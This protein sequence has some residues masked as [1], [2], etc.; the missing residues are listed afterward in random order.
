MEDKWF[1]LSDPE[2]VW[3]PGRFVQDSGDSSTYENKDGEIIHRNNS[4]AKDFKEL[5][6][7][8]LN[9]E[10][11]NLIEMEEFSEGAILH[12]IRQ[13]YFAD[14]IYTN[15]GS[16]LVSVNPFKELQIYTPHILS[17]YKKVIE[18]NDPHV[19]QVAS[20]ALH[21]LLKDRQSQ[22]VIIS[23]E[24]GSGKTEATKLILQYLGDTAGSKDGVEQQILQSNPILEA[25]GNCKTLRNKNSSR[26]GKWMEI[27]FKSGKICGAKIINYLLEKSRVNSQAK[28]ERNYHAFYQLCQGIPDDLRE[29]L[30]VHTA[31][32]FEFLKKSE[33]FKVNGIDDFRDFSVTSLAFQKLQFNSDEVENV[34]RLLSGILWLG[35]INFKSNGDGSEISDPNPLNIASELL[36][37]DSK[38]LSDA[39]CYKKLLIR[40][41]VQMKNQDAIQ[42]ANARD[43][44]AKEIYGRLFDWLVQKINVFLGTGKSSSTIGVLDIFGFEVFEKNAFEQFCINYANEKLQQHFNHYIFKM[45]QNEY[46][47]EGVPF[48]TVSFVDNQAC[49]DLIE[50]NPGILS[51]IEEEV[52]FPQGSDENLAEK[53]HSTFA[54]SKKE[55][56]AH[57]K[58]FRQKR[59]AFI[60]SHYAGD[61]SYTSTG[62]CDKSKDEIHESLQ[63]T[64]L[65]STNFLM[66]Q[67]F[68]DDVPEKSDTKRGH[69]R[70]GSMKKSKTIGSKFKSQLTLLMKTLNSTKPH[71][72]RCIKPNNLMAGN[73]FDSSSSLRQFRYAGLF[74]AIRVRASGYSFR[75]PL[76]DFFKHYRFLV[77]LGERKKIEMLNAK[78]KCKQVLVDYQ[79]QIPSDDL[80]LGE[81]KMFYRKNVYLIL[82]SIRDTRLREYVVRM[83]C[84]S[85][86]FL[87]GKKLQLLRKA[88]KCIQEAI[89]KCTI[90]ATSEAMAFVE[91]FNIVLSVVTKLKSIHNALKQE[92]SIIENLQVAITKKDIDAIE[93]VLQQA[94]S[95]GLYDLTKDQSSKSVIDEAKISLKTFKDFHGVAKR[96]KQAIIEEDIKTLQECVQTSK[97]AG[98]TDGVEEAEKYLEKF[99]RDEALMKCIANAVQ[100]CDIPNLEDLLQKVVENKVSF[101]AERRKL[102]ADTKIAITDFYKCKIE[103]AVVSEDQEGIRDI[104]NQVQERQYQSLLRD[105]I[106]EAQVTLRRL[107]PSASFSEIAQEQDDFLAPLPSSPPVSPEIGLVS[108]SLPPFIPMIHETKPEQVALKHAVQSADIASV[109]K[110]VPEIEQKSSNESKT[111]RVGRAMIQKFNEMKVIR[112]NLEKAVNSMDRERMKAI[113]QEAREFDMTDD[114]F[115]VKAKKICYGMQETEFRMLQMEIAIRQEDLQR[116]K[117]IVNICQEQIDCP[118]VVTEGNTFISNY[119]IAKSLGAVRSKDSTSVSFESQNVEDLSELFQSLKGL[120]QLRN[121]PFLRSPSGIFPFSLGGSRS[122]ATMLIHQHEPISKSMLKFSSFVLKNDKAKSLKIEAK[123]IFKGILGFMGDRYHP[124]PNTLA[125]EILFRG[126]E[127]PNLRDEIF[128]QIIKQTSENPQEASLLRGWKLLFLALVTFHPNSDLVRKIILSH[129]AQVATP[130]IPKHLSFDTLENIA[131]NCYLQLQKN[132]DPDVEVP[133]VERIRELSELKSSTFYV[134][135]PSGNTID[136]PIAA[137]N[138]SLTVG[139][140][141]ALICSRLRIKMSSQCKLS[142]QTRDEEIN[143][144]YEFIVRNEDL[145]LSLLSHWQGERRI[146]PNLEYR[147]VFSDGSSFDGFQITPQ[148]VPTI[149][150][151]FIPP[152]SKSL[153]DPS[154]I[155]NGI[156][157]SSSGSFPPVDQVFQ[158]M[159]YEPVPPAPPAP[160][161]LLSPPAPPAPSKLLN[162][163]IAF[164]EENLASPPSKIPPLD[165]D[166]Q[167][168]PTVMAPPTP[169]PIP[170][171][172]SQSAK[173]ALQREASEFS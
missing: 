161:S 169:P 101:D 66:Q 105:E 154:I 6:V 93:G 125:H 50:K 133:T 3:V 158:P 82:E 27:S 75:Q 14:R 30:H 61:V 137:T 17:K 141:I 46:K 88:E 89:Q 112:L 23:G 117:D 72:I 25:F 45:E 55:T 35:N 120:H 36:E 118:D 94:E 173:S 166:S 103:A 15:I 48:E 106:L 115:V 54:K 47:K 62:F 147:F 135:V 7:S 143:F 142:V 68:N 21:N 57:Y 58:V 37:I 165:S 87:A 153:G 100:T 44:T 74:E 159:R 163:P 38:I 81:T 19:Y 8:S 140:A 60:V 160:L 109:Q 1:W 79:S 26:F 64:V 130:L 123:N 31:E 73:V 85:R 77:E 167:M 145:I 157:D 138:K 155:S 127:E 90:N 33:C 52:L 129:V 34:W 113:L 110:L 32:H 128:C 56:H 71:F 116:V 67:I 78:E 99:L 53:L 11:S 39:F 91:D 10:F 126:R 164:P 41:E 43:S 9:Q 18:D 49:L 170:T 122:V 144:K 131:A 148:D 96:M 51:L 92:P 114:D 40:G 172:I 42:A 168:K 65:S 136:I 98:F 70:V 83:Q 124:Y 63:E 134:Q 146:N 28:N 69:R 149:E 12:Q 132:E 4:E 156:L 76:E 84:V 24:S 102:M 162:S 29:K 95:L 108:T 16:I 5:R 119:Y 59:E 152:A 97:S 139:G 86:A 111:I 107:D 80:K 171:S 20:I 104:L 2:L 121:H 151:E 150:K 22:S 13:R